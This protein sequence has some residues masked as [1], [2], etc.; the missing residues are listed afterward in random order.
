M[1]KEDWRIFVHYNTRLLWILVDSSAFMSLKILDIQFTARI[2]YFS[3]FFFKCFF[4]PFPRRSF[5]CEAFDLGDSGPA[6][7]GS[8]LLFRNT[9]DNS[10]NSARGAARAVDITFAGCRNRLLLFSTRKISWLNFKIR[11]SR[12]W[13]RQVLFSTW[14]TMSNPKNR[15]LYITQYLKTNHISYG[16]SQ[17]K[18][19]KQYLF[20]MAKIY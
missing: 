3:A 1:F 16:L 17:H 14:L 2:F 8:S 15:Y 12:I 20:I 7:S 18:F 6:I 9:G 10:S 11:I 13:F 4:F 19:R 5:E